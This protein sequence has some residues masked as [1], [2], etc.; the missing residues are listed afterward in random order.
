MLSLVPPVLGFVPFV[1]HDIYTYCI[2]GNLLAQKIFDLLISTVFS[3]SDNALFEFFVQ[4]A[5]QPGSVR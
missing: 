4:D 2:T 5:R 1:A 3:I